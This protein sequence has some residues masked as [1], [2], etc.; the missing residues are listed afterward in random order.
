VPL[1]PGVVR[2]AVGGHAQCEA[3]C[4]DLANQGIAPDRMLGSAL[5]LAAGLAARQDGPAAFLF[6]GGRTRPGSGAEGDPAEQARYAALLGSRE[7]LP[8]FAAP[9]AGDVTGAGAGGFTSAFARA[10]APFG[11]TAASGIT[12]V[13]IGAAPG[14]GARTH[15]AFDAAT[16]AGTVRVIVIDNGAGSLA[17]SDPHQNPAEPQ[18]PWLQ[19]VLRD[20]RARQVPA[21]VVGSR[22]LN[23]RAVPPLNVASDGDRI[24]ALLVAEGASAYL[25]DRPEENRASRIPAGAQDT[26]P[27]FGTGSLG[28]RSSIADAASVGLPDALFGDGGI[29]LLEVAAS[30]RD[31]QTNR[32][33]VSVRLIPVLDDLALQPLDGTLLR[34][35]RPSLFQGLGRRPVGGDR[36][37][38][39]SGDGVPNPSGADPYTSFPS[40]PCRIAGCA[41]KIQPEYTF[42]SSAPDVLDFVRQDPASANLRKPLLGA[43]DKVISDAA[44]GL[45]CPFNAGSAEVTVAAGGRALT[46]TIQV[47]PGSVQRP[48]GTRPL[49]PSRIRRVA[50]APPAAAAPPPPASAPPSVL[51]ALVPPP[52]PPAPA[53]RPERPERPTPRPPAELPFFAPF[54][55]APPGENASPPATP[56]PPPATFFANPIPPGGATVRVQEEEREEEAAPEQSAAAVAYRAE[57]HLPL[58]P[59]LLGMAL[60]AALAG[61][62]IFRGGRRRDPHLALTRVT[63]DD[64]HRVRST[65]STP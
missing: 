7:R 29:L 36:W 60:L 39:V 63:Y 35:S 10:P 42:A 50:Q 4:A 58:E 22:D 49:D 52:P 13:A 27:A 45:V 32:A 17:A 16:G 28:Y 40:D 3:A 6:T 38:Q 54:T 2:F 14:P 64:H 33:P 11:T 9:S 65:R 31:P 51:P 12:P 46:Q 48:C 8:V 56:P 41:S 59:F 43:D 26:I 23:T 21:I 57:E 1:T 34:R 55:D 24:A 20:A 18:E 19:A 62:S 30:A 5:D 37:G 61:V 47:L 15:Y 53:E 25:F 44:S